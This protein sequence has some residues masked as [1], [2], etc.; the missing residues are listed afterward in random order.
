VRARAVSARRRGETCDVALLDGLATMAGWGWGQ[1]E[2]IGIKS[3][4][5]PFFAAVLRIS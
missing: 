3:T 2:S 1:I 4:S 5:F